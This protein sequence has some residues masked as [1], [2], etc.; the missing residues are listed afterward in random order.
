MEKKMIDEIREF[1]QNFIAP[2]FEGIKGDLRA[3]DTKIDARSETMNAKIDALDVKF[4]TKLEVVLAKID[5]VDSKV[6]S[7]RRELLAEIRAAIR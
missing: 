4:N 7:Y 3:L 5:S 2:Q 6:E 1:F